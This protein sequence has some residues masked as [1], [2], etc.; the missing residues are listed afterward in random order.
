MNLD[1]KFATDFLSLSIFI[2]YFNYKFSV[3]MAIQKYVRS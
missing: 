3:S 2:T 1:S